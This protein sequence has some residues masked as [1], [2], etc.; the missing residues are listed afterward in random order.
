MRGLV[1]GLVLF[2]AGC[3]MIGI[4]APDQVPHDQPLECSDH[5]ALPYVDTAAAALLLGT[6]GLALGASGLGYVS[7]DYRHGDNA[8]FIMLGILIG[9]PT[10]FVGAIYAASAHHGYGAIRSC[11]GA[12]TERA[13][14]LEAEAERTRKAD[15]R[16]EAWTITKLAAEAAR[17]ADCAKVKELDV[18]VQGLD[19]D[20]HNTVFVRDVA[21]ARCLAG[22]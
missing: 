5:S 3:S 2:T 22:P 16:A 4:R 13:I 17:A 6:G 9:V 12:H 8:L 10:S 1:V 18:E 21:I 7:G 15:A 19:L 14:E 20:F 11:K